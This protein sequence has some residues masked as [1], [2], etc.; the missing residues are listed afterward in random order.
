MQKEDFNNCL[1]LIRNN[2]LNGLKGIYNE[3]YETMEFTA[4]KKVKNREAAKTIADNL[5]KDLINNA[6]DI[7]AVD[8]P[9]LWIYENI[10]KLAEDY[11][12][13][14]KADNKDF[15]DE[16]AACF[17]SLNEIEQEIVLLFYFYHISHLEIA[18][19]LKMPIETVKTY[20]K[21]INALQ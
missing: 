17:L 16:L 8:N 10:N 12:E 18:Q 21:N 9:D 1:N 5:L 7:K 14:S 13:N 19:R 15:N 3:Y 2:N 11:L 6:K 4:L 20:L